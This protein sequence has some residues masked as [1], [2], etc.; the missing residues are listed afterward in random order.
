MRRAPRVL[1][2]V[3]AVLLLI[4]AAGAWYVSPTPPTLLKSGQR[5]QAVLYHEY[6]SPAVLHLENTEK[7]LPDA[8]QVLIKVQ[9]AAANPLDWHHMRGVPYVIR[10]GTGW[11]RPVDTRLGV[12]VSGTVEKVGKNV[13]QFKA[14]DAV[15]GAGDGA[16]AEY[17]LASQDNIALK[18]PNL[19]FA[20]AAAVPIAALTALQGLRDEGRLRAGQHVLVNGASGGVGTFAVQLAKW[21]GAQV[22][23]VCSTRNVELVRSLG[24]DRVIDYTRE[25]LA[26]SPE[27][28]DLILDNV[29]N[30]P[31][32][33]FKGLLNPQGTYVLIGGGGPGENGLLG[34][35]TAPIKEFFYSPFVTQRFV[36][37]LA[38]VDKKDLGILKDLLQ[39]GKIRP[40]LDKTYPLSETPAAMRYLEAG[41]A[42]GKVIIVPSG[43]TPGAP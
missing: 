21:L 20:Q 35:L 19:T 23:G 26:R 34:P 15:F 11:R 7:P 33:Q 39:T 43:L 24:A 12:D 32:A 37:L 17:A 40:V 14:G 13:T 29:G 10:M 8:N 1:L 3:L 22:T 4:V 38:S 27:K 18:P 28:F 31:L 5:M 25:D 2:I 6:G 9:A 42:H 30:R 36:M 16:F 41:H